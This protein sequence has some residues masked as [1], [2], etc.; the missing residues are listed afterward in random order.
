MEKL[1]KVNRTIGEHLVRNLVRVDE[2]TIKGEVASQYNEESWESVTYNK[3]SI[4]EN[5]YSCM[6]GEWWDIVL[7]D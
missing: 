1:D 2:K 7:N 6:L 3:C 4:D 5:Y